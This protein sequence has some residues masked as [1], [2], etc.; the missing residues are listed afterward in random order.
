MRKATTRM[1][2]LIKRLNTREGGMIVSVILGLG[3]AA[4]FR[5][6]CQGN[7]CVVLRSPPMKQVRDSVYQV[8]DKCYR[9]QPQVVQCPV[10]S[11]GT[12]ASAE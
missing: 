10:N 3:L 11:D 1:Q 12:V 7:S 4:V 6:A 9:Y 5:Q 2:Q 8:E